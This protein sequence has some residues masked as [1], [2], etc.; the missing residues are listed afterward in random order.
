MFTLAIDG[1]AVAITDADEEQARELFDSE[2][3]KNDLKTMTEGGE[4]LWNGTGSFNVRRSTDEE[5]DS[6]DDAMSDDEDEAEDDEEDGINVLF[7]VPIDTDEDQD[8]AAS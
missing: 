2:E 8:E 4:P 7:L 3:F 6:Y 1:R 5:I